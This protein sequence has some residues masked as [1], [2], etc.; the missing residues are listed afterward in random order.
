L[1][2]L[3]YCICFLYQL[4]AHIMSLRVNVFL[5]PFLLDIL[6]SLVLE[7]GADFVC[8]LYIFNKKLLPLVHD[9]LFPPLMFGC[10]I[11]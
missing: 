9:A 11:L 1:Q 8:V 4:F 5:F 2:A 10:K 7:K 3:K 6:T